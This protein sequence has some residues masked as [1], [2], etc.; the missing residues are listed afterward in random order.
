ML[1]NAWTLL[2]FGANAAVVIMALGW[3]IAR[4]AKNATYLEVAWSY[5]FAVLVWIYALIGPGDPLRKWLIT[6]MVTIWS[7]RL[8]T[9]FFFDVMRHHPAEGRRYVA[10]R[11]QFPKRPWLMFFA[12]SQYQAALLGLLS[13]PFAIA[14]FGSLR[15]RERLWR[16][17]NSTAFD[18]IRKIPATRVMRDSGDT[19]VAPTASLSGSFGWPTSSFRLVHRGGGSLFIARCSSFIS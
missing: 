7:L 5:G 11:D 3:A 6:G 8:G 14:F 4:R 2:G 15:L 1:M 17:S 13:A 19:R 18:P 16:I 12:F 10:L 9:S